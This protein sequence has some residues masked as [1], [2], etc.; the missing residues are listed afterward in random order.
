LRDRFPS[1]GGRTWAAPLAV[2]AGA[3]LGVASAT[4]CPVVQS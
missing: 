3:P 1:L 2:V 4:L